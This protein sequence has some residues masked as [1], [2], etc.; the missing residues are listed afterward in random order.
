MPQYKTPPRA[1]LLRKV[2]PLSPW[3]IN[4]KKLDE[5]F[6]KADLQKE[7]EPKFDRLTDKDDAGIISIDERTGLLAFKASDGTHYLQGH[8][9]Y[10]CSRV[11]CYEDPWL[12]DVPDNCGYHP[13]QW[14]FPEQYIPCGENCRGA[15]CKCL[16]LYVNRL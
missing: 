11:R 14:T 9:R 7:G 4:T 16:H 10:K 8:G 13:G 5:M 3:S 1:H 6:D 2:R 12:T 15:F